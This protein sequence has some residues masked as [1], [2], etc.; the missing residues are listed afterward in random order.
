MGEVKK[1]AI[2]KGVSSE[3]ADLI[4]QGYDDLIAAK[5]KAKKER[6]GKKLNEEKMAVDSERMAIELLPEP[7]RPYAKLEYQNGGNRVVIQ[8]PG[9]AVISRKVWVEKA[10]IDGQEK[11]I[12]AHWMTAGDNIDFRI[13]QYT[14][15]EGEVHLHDIGFGDLSNDPL[16]ALALA[17]EFGDTKEKAEADAEKQRADIKACEMRA[18]K[19]PKRDEYSDR[20][21]CPFNGGQSGNAVC[22]REKCALWVP[23]TNQSGGC[24]ILFIGQP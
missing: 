1:I 16:R 9:C 3:L 6:E 21:F 7:M 12:K 2:H 13:S 4:Q 10:Y 14:A 22:D 17:A 15:D 5:E 24:G 8:I 18:A 23:L 19:T 20:M 11:V